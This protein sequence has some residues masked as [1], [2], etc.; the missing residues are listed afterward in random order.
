M[1]PGVIGLLR[2][3]GNSIMTEGIAYA[4]TLSWGRHMG[5]EHCDLRSP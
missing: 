5:P 3:A 4:K 1:S 2:K